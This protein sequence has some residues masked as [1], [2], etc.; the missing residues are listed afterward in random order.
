MA[1]PDDRPFAA[2]LRDIMVASKISVAGLAESSGINA[3]LIAR[4]R[5]GETEPRD[6]Y[7]EPSINAHRLANALD[8]DVGAL[9]PAKEV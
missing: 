3:R 1:R 2:R 5:A 7:G 6:A 9:L 4:Y 8:V